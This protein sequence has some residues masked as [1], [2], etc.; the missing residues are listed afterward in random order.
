VTKKHDPKIVHINPTVI[1]FFVCAPAEG[2][3]SI[4]V[5]TPFLERPN[6]SVSICIK[7]IPLTVSATTHEFA[8]VLRACH[9]CV[10]ALSMEKSTLEISFEHVASRTTK[11]AFAISHSI[12]EVSNVVGAIGLRLVTLTVHSTLLDERKYTHK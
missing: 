2:E 10:F 5:S 6:V 9:P 12:D 8:N 3:H 7:Q 1:V 11:D 4:A